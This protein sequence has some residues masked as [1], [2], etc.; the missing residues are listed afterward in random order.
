MRVLLDDDRRHAIGL[1]PGDRLEDL[2]G[3]ARR[4]PGRGLVEHQELRLAHQ[5]A[6]DGHHLLFAP[7]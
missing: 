3:D 1:E 6:A 7:R 2:F 5:R 4:K